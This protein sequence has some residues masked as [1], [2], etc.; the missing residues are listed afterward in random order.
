M[1]IQAV[2]DDKTL[3]IEAAMANP[4]IRAN[5]RLLA[6]IG[7]ERPTVRIPIH[8]LEAKMSDAGLDPKKRIELKIALERAGLLAV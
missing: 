2:K 6:Q 3:N 7:L 1:Q 5:A 4:A 8:V